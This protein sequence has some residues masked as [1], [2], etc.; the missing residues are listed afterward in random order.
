MS[1]QSCPAQTSD[2]RRPT[3]KMYRSRATD[4]CGRDRPMATRRG[5]R[6]LSTRRP[7]R[8]RCAARSNSTACTRSRS[9]RSAATARQSLDASHLEHRHRREPLEPVGPRR[10]H[11]GEAC[12]QRS[13]AAAYSTAK[14]RLRASASIRAHLLRVATRGPRFRRGSTVADRSRHACASTPRRPS[15]RRPLCRSR[16]YDYACVIPQEL[17][18]AQVSQP[19][20]SQSLDICKIRD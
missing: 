1:W 16:V 11:D 10:R 12:R 4:T 17:L 19:T 15:T 8:N 5:S 13:R 14:L 9:S 6:R 18:I 20:E 3:I 2:Y 7:V